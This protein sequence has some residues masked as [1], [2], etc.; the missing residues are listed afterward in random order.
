MWHVTNKFSTVVP[1]EGRTAYQ[2][3]LP[4]VVSPHLYREGDPM[5]FPSAAFK[6]APQVFKTLQNPLTYQADL[7]FVWQINLR[8][9]SSFRDVTDLSSVRLS[10]QSVLITP[11]L[12]LRNSCAKRC[13]PRKA[14]DEKR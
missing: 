12:A 1:R 8:D 7:S 13:L 3:H 6:H 5:F 14:D 10:T 4:P 11:S 2:T 9:G